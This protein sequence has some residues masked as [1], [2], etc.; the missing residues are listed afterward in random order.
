MYQK[1]H[2]LGSLINPAVQ[3]HS[4]AF[5]TSAQTLQYSDTC[6]LIVKLATM[7]NVDGLIERM[8]RIVFSKGRFQSVIT[9]KNCMMKIAEAV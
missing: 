5:Y 1:K 6:V 4:L 9:I 2:G 3:V 8:E 7:E